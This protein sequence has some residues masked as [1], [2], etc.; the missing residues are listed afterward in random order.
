MIRQVFSSPKRMYWMLA[1][2]LVGLVVAQLLFVS[3]R[4]EKYP[5]EVKGITEAKL[6]SYQEA[7]EVVIIEESVDGASEEESTVNQE[8]QDLLGSLPTQVLS[9][10]IGYSAQK[11]N[12][13]EDKYCEVR[14]LFT[15]EE[16][17]DA[18][19]DSKTSLAKIAAR[20]TCD[21]NAGRRI[22]KAGKN[23]RSVKE[24]GNRSG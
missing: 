10:P 13:G 23:G 22:G 12:S 15:P 21:K 9:L 7:E 2:V 14:E 11:I 24:A 1:I 18:F 19:T 5:E 20:D 6:G 8:V 17:S 4:T 3:G 16:V